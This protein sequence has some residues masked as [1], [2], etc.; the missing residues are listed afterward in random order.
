MPCWPK[1]V[2]TTTPV[3]TSSWAPR[4]VNT[5]G[6]APSASQTQATVTSS[7]VCLQ[8]KHKQKHFDW[9]GGGHQWVTFHFERNLK[10]R[11]V[12]LNTPSLGTL[13]QTT[14]ACKIL[15]AYVTDRQTPFGVGCVIANSI[16]SRGL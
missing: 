8:E 1:L 13:S 15:T 6:C 9:R 14:C 12:D 10:G 5:S 4:A 3:T 7:A 16:W 2:S 11:D